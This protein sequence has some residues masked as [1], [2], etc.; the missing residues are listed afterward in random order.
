MRASSPR[1]S[2]CSPSARC[3]PASASSTSTWFATSGNSL[4]RAHSTNAC[5]SRPAAWPR[6]VRI[7]AAAERTAARSRIW[8]AVTSGSSISR[9]GPGPRPTCR[10]NR[11]RRPHP[12]ERQA[13]TS[14]PRAARRTQ[15][16]YAAVAARPAAAEALPARQQ[17][18]HTASPRS[19]PG[20][21]VLPD[22]VPGS[23]RRGRR[24][25]PDRSAPGRASRAP[26]PTRA[27]RA[28]GRAQVRERPPLQRFHCRRRP[29][30][31]PPSRPSL[32]PV[33]RTAAR[34]QE[35]RQP[36]RPPPS[37]WR[38]PAARGCRRGDRS[39]RPRP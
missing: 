18:S 14:G 32:S 29:H 24:H 26:A 9:A 30:T 12:L 8:P 11:D 16:P 1:A 35:E 23:D 37:P 19:D 25:H 27:A 36:G 39:Q 28:P 17:D 7:R 13:G 21:V 2:S 38:R 31:W 5:T 34:L 6:A 20:P 33:R 10:P 4:P 3:T 15:D 22:P